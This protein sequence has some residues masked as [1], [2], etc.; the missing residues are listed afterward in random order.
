MSEIRRAAAIS[1]AT[2]LIANFSGLLLTPFIIRSLG[3]SE[4]GLYV[5]VGS[6]TAH[7]GVLNFGLNTA[8]TRYVAESM[9]R[10]DHEQKARF[11]GAALLIN[12]LAVI[13]I[14]GGGT[15]I[16]LQLDVW[17]NQSLDSAEIEK[18]RA[19]LLLLVASVACTITANMFG[20]ISAGHEKFVFSKAINILRYVVRIALVPAILIYGGGAVAL[21][22]L[23]AALSVLVLLAN[24]M[25]ALRSAAARFNLRSLDA[26]L[27]GGVLKFSLWVFIYA[28]IVKIQWQT[29]QVIIGAR[30]GPEA[31]GVYGIG[32][33]FGTY[34][35]AF[36]GAITGLFLP[37]AT[38]MTV[39]GADA[40]V[41]V[42]QMVRIGR[43]ALIIL[44]LILGGF[45]FFGREFLVLWAGP[46]YEESW[47]VALLIMV[48]YTVPLI[49]AF[50]SHLLQARGLI[51]F[52]AKLYLITLPVGVGLGYFMLDEHGVLG[53]A[54]GMVAGWVVATVLINVYYHRVLGLDV[55]KFFLE[56]S[57][58]F[59]PV[60][61]VCLAVGWGLNLIPGNGWIMLSVRVLAFLLIYSTLLHR[62]AMNESERR[63]VSAIRKRLT[64]IWG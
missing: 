20:A 28:V 26:K 34:Y 33:M 42:D 61:I 7:L 47:G 55:P 50:A 23:D 38:R 57:R 64:W 4:Y 48:G 62:Y 37:R 15:L 8:V 59:L 39:V 36:S 32:I 51:A 9:A 6:L 60:F 49:Q 40:T 10:N 27:I 16:Y 14:A 21:V 63:E 3:S 43:V 46:D 54:A 5:L 17:F 13:A 35:G 2:I 41:L 58:G 56:V 24:M 19:M 45:Y 29:G 30:I 52:K 22:A 25:Y 44:L 1:Y 53:M 31:V 11:L 18:A 12:M